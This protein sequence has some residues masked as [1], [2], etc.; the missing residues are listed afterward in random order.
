MY[1]GLH[2]VSKKW[3]WSFGYDYVL[4]AIHARLHVVV[5]DVLFFLFQFDC[6]NYEVALLDI[7]R[8]RRSGG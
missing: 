1:A 8:K 5:A 3:W 7:E 2:A 4:D 6:Y